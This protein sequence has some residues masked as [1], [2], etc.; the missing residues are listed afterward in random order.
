MGF[1][2]DQFRYT[3]DIFTDNGKHNVDQTN[4]PFNYTA[5]KIR[6]YDTNDTGFARDTST[7]TLQLKRGFMRNLNTK[8][9]NVGTRV[10]PSAYK[11]QF[12]FNPTTIQQNV[13]ARQDMYLSILQDP[14]QLTQ[15]VAG[16]TSFSFELLFDRTHELM[17]GGKNAN[18]FQVPTG[19][20]PA[21]NTSGDAADIGVLADL[22]V[23]YAIIGQGF[24][25]ETLEA[26][27]N[28][29]R[30]NARREYE[31]AIA[32]GDPLFAQPEYDERNRIY[33]ERGTS[34]L[35][36]AG[37]DEYFRTVMDKTG[38]MPVTFG[39]QNSS[40]LNLGN[41]AFLVPMPVRI[42][43]S[44]L[45]MVDGYVTSTNVIFTKFN[46]NMVPI[47]CRVLLNMHAAYIGFARDQTFISYN[48]EQSGEQAR[49]EYDAA[50]KELRDFCTEY[51]KC[52]TNYKV[53]LSD[54]G[55]AFAPELYSNDP[56]NSPLAYT[57]AT[58]GRD[59]S[60][61][62]EGDYPKITAGFKGLG[63][64]DVTVDQ[65]PL[66]TWGGVKTMV[67][68]GIHSYYE[69][70]GA[71][72]ITRE[73]TVSVYGPF[74]SSEQASKQGRN[75]A[76]LVGKYVDSRESG[77]K[78]E[79]IRGKSIQSRDSG[80]FSVYNKDNESNSS[81]NSIDVKEFF[82]PLKN[83]SDLS[84]DEKFDVKVQ[85]GNAYGGK[86]FAFYADVKV[87]IK[88]GDTVEPQVREAS[89]TEAKIFKGSEKVN[90]TSWDLVL[91]SCS[92]PKTNTRSPRPAQP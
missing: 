66:D 55:K 3:P 73:T 69:D 22:S 28:V 61:I 2:E 86:Y 71:I 54:N 75:S 41:S 19:Q 39:D 50:K 89:S 77:S 20:D 91:Q 7:I 23:M 17:N 27:Y 57:Y 25:A 74:D 14:Y 38:F 64:V 10:R 76:Y 11:L 31:R 59:S 81:P 43:F 52:L 48:I 46:T 16:S 29:V 49:E 34:D 63:C 21:D 51:G 36:L 33:K 90:D 45:Y 92:V 78:D 44:A 53:T 32:S 40:N 79:W 58:K 65:M 88:S 83:I 62:L 26:Q 68:G 82:P 37:F 84:D 70:G 72:S 9:G 5:N 18:I 4:P 13:E 30:E 67:E 12:Q 8:W 87:T 60:D 24:S 80:A 85:F 42:V 6:I 56:D 1:R 35:T 15:P 47:Q